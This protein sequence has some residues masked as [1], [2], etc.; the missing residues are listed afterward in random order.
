MHSGLR[1]SLEL[2]RVGFGPI[3]GALVLAVG[4]ILVNPLVPTLGTDVGSVVSILTAVIGFLGVLTLAMSLSVS[5]VQTTIDR[6]SG[7]GADE[8]LVTLVVQDHDRD[9]LLQLIVFAVTVSLAEAILVTTG[10]V[11]PGLAALPSIVLSGLTLA[12]FVG[13]VRNRIALFDMRALG[14]HLVARSR[15]MRGAVERKLPRPGQRVGKERLETLVAAIDEYVA[16]PDLILVAARRALANG[17]MGA[18]ELLLEQTLTCAR[19]T[20]QISRR[21]PWLTLIHARRAVTFGEAS[22]A[23]A[24]GSQALAITI[25]EPDRYLCAVVGRHFVELVGTSTVADAELPGTPFSHAPSGV[26]NSGDDPLG[27]PY[28]DS[29]LAR[30]DALARRGSIA[31]SAFEMARVY[32][33]ARTN[34]GGVDPS[35]WVPDP[36]QPAFRPIIFV[37]AKCG[38]TGEQRDLEVRSV[39]VMRGA[40]GRG[41][42][43][44]VCSACG[45]LENEDLLPAV[46]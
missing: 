33:T 26:S 9:L 42:L 12:I 8:A 13:Y 41:F 11:G 45:H 32:S 37:G 6:F 28:W 10:V 7:Q 14:R 2:A 19:E 25:E 22:V 4:T 20:R 40:R 23:E 5:L 15:R 31:S 46:D 36:A 21:A 17:D 18:G 39:S 27:A 35:A 30:F 38:T 16:F 3:L 43:D 24:M 44:G 1:P 34:P 29:L